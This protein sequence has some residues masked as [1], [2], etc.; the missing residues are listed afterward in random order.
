MKS[1]TQSQP[2]LARLVE[3]QMRN[4]ELAREQRFEAGKPFVKR[5]HD[6]VTLSRA[7]GVG[8]EEVCRLLG[9]RLGWPV[10]D[11]ELLQAMAGDD[12]LRQ[13]VYR[14]MD[15]RQLSWVEEIARSVLQ[16]EFVKNDYFHRLTETVLSLAAQGSAVFVGRGVDLILQRDAGL[17][18]R[19]VAPMSSRVANLIEREGLSVESAEREILRRDEEQTQFVRRH[20]NSDVRDPAR[21]DLVLNTVCFAPDHLA[22]LICRARRM[23][24]RD[25]ART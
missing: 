11:R 4:W 8:G 13:R 22:E 23:R 9:E 19:L 21:Y 10:F 20:F 5:T 6:F 17:R 12:D 7:P 18:V 25:S 2:E 1:A 14:S 16:P 24:G 15:E 3:R